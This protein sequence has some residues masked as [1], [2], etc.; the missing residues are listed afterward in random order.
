MGDAYN[1][2]LMLR[3]WYGC[4]A[5]HG[6]HCPPLLLQRIHH[7]VAQLRERQRVRQQLSIYTLGKLKIPRT[8]LHMAMSEA[9]MLFHTTIEHLKAQIEGNG[10]VTCANCH[11]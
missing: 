6:L 11:T 9:G 1:Q 10:Y 5:Y 4:I 2:G 7:E 3:P 8:Q